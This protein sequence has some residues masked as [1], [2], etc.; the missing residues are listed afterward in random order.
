MKEMILLLSMADVESLGSIRTRPGLSVSVDGDSLWVRGIPAQQAMDKQLQ[1]LPVL[2]T[3]LM[4]EKE[5]LYLPGMLT[6]HDKLKRLSWEALSSFLKVELPVSALPAILPE[7]YAIRL[8]PAEN[9][10]LPVALL[11]TLTQWKAYADTAPL[12][13]LQQLRFAV[14]EQDH[15]LIA[16]NPVPSLP[17]KTYILRHNMLLPAGYDF[18]PPAIAPLV[19]NRLNPGNDALL[20]FHKDGQ[21]ERIPGQGFVRAARS[22]IRLTNSTY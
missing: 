18:D 20:L 22:A 9:T 7:K 21:W 19:A 8:A 11:T 17:G 10:G 3:F 13:R 14:S 15:V 4:D 6:P 12:I 5:R 2:Q 1:Q 16:G